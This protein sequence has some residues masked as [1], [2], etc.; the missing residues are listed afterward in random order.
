MGVLLDNIDMEAQRAP[1]RVPETEGE[2]ALSE[3]SYTVQG[4][5]C[6]HCA[7]AVRDEVGR[8][9]GVRDV[10][11]DL[12]TGAVSVISDQPV[13]AEEIHAAITEAGYELVASPGRKPIGL[14]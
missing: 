7:G 3:S 2:T 10:H 8:L 9:D 13:A 11:I 1:N 5:T 14:D 6:D 12:A 4:M